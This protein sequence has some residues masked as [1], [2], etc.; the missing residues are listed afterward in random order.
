MQRLT[1][2][3][4]SVISLAVLHTPAFAAD[5]DM[6]RNGYS[7][8]LL[9]DVECKSWISSRRDLERRG[10]LKSLQM[11]DQKMQAIMEE[12]AYVCPCTWDRSLKGVNH[13]RSARF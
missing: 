10:D 12:R 7:T 3:T 13:T 1:F 5:E 2:L 6:C 4:L 9:T 11:L 8:M